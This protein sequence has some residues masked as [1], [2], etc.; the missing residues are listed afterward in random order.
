MADKKFK[1]KYGNPSL[2]AYN[3]YLYLVFKDTK[4]KIFIFFPDTLRPLE[5]VM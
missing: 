3:F 2:A 1:L 4:I 5:T